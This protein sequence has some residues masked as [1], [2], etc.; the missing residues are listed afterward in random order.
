VLLG[1]DVRVAGATEWCRVV[2]EELAIVARPGSGLAEIAR[3][4]LSTPGISAIAGLVGVGKTQFA[5]PRC[6]AEGR[7]WDVGLL[8]LRH[9]SAA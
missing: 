1:R 4:E 5:V 6:I 3:H 7:G 9:M 2:G 8:R